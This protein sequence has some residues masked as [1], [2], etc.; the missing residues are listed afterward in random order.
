M[1]LIVSS[2]TGASPENRLL[3]LDAV[4]GEQPAAVGHPG[5]DER[6]VRG[7]AGHDEPA[8]VLFEP[9]ERRH[10]PVVAVQEPGLAEPASSAATCACQRVSRVAARPDP[11]AEGRQ[12]AGDD[13][14]LQQRGGQPVDL[15]A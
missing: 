12:V 10:A 3:M 14:P 13:R 8:G 11:A 1:P 7:L 15:D 4:V 2:D 9:A 6:G 5:L